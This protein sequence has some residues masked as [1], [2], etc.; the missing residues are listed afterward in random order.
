MELRA[1]SPEAYALAVLP[2]TAALWSGGRTFDQ[3][4]EQ[5]LAIAHSVYGR[6]SYRTVGLFERRELLASCKRYERRITFGERRLRAIGIGAVFTAAPLRGHGYATAMLAMLL[7]EARTA[8]NDLA[9]LFSDIRPEFYADLGFIEL[10]SRAFSLRASAVKAPRVRVEALSPR[11]WPGVRRCYD[12]LSHLQPWSLERDAALWNRVRARWERSFDKLGTT[13]AANLLLRRGGKVVAYVLG[14]RDVRDDAYTLD[15][16]GFLD[17]ATAELVPSLLLAAA[18]DLRRIT[19]WLPPSGARE[20]L[21]AVSVRKRK[22][23]IFM[24]AGLSLIGRT[25]VSQTAATSKAD[26]LWATDHV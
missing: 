23:A 13:R 18:G 11:D 22:T 7:D 14:T 1:I 16:F 4:V 5:T 20:V 21:P 19:G 26:P 15:E 6:R 9:F 8:G 17:E 25:L 2:H 12:A 10:A 3:Y 24:A